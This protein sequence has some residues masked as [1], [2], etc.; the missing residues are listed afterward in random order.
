MYMLKSLKLSRVKAHSR[1]ISVVYLCVRINSSVMYFFLGNFSAM[2]RCTSR[3]SWRRTS[4]PKC[5]TLGTDAARPV[6][7]GQCSHARS[8]S[9]PVSLSRHLTSYF[10]PKVK[11]KSCL[12]L[13]LGKLLSFWSKKDSETVFLWLRKNPNLK[14]YTARDNF[15]KK[16]NIS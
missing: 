10:V 2:E 5:T 14:L 7:W 11:A 8:L 3:R 4:E 1:F 16:L 12:D 9:A 6:L 15:G 13:M